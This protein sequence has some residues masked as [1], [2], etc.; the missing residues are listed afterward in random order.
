MV[1]IIQGRESEYEKKNPIFGIARQPIPAGTDTNDPRIQIHEKKNPKQSRTPRQDSIVHKS[2]QSS[3]T[4]SAL[5]KIP[6]TPHHHE[7]PLGIPIDIIGATPARPRGSQALPI[8]GSSHPVPV[9]I[10]SALCRSAA[11]DISR[12]ASPNMIDRGGVLVLAE[13]S[14]QFLVEREDSPL[15]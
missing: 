1:M 10:H 13:L 9:D 12:T 8:L 4:S 7:S 15:G 11:G 6:P 3:T 2:K 14:L 5:Q